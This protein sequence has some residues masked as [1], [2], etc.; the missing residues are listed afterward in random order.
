MI[1]EIAEDFCLR[2]NSLVPPACLLEFV[3]SIP[4]PPLAD[5][6]I[7]RKATPRTLTRN[8]QTLAHQH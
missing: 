2:V 3:R 8:L 7:L 5:F 1:T 4:D 6:Q